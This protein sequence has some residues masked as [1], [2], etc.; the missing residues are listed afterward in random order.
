MR[1]RRQIDQRVNGFYVECSVQDVVGVDVVDLVVRSAGRAAY[2]I[3]KYEDGA[4][5]LEIEELGIGNERSERG[6]V[7]ASESVGPIV[8]G[9]NEGRIWIRD[10]FPRIGWE[11]VGG[12]FIGVGNGCCGVATLDIGPLKLQCI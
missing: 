7:E 4:L 9:A 2:L 10:P 6:A 1:Q 5:G 8:R 12:C 3:L 11:L